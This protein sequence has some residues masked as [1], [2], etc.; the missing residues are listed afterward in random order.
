M[1]RRRLPKVIMRVS[2]DDMSGAPV[3]LSAADVQSV[4]TT[5]TSAHVIAVFG[6][7][8]GSRG[9]RCRDGAGGGFGVEYFAAASIDA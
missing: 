6:A 8:F 5:E 1:S 4:P 7:D 9:Q 3:G 2:D